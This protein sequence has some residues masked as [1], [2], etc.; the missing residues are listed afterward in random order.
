MVSNNQYQGVTFLV[1]PFFIPCRELFAG[2][3]SQSGAVSRFP[4]QSFAKR[5]FPPQATGNP[6]QQ[7]D[8]RCNRG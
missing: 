1:A 4:L 5:D 7:K 8:F 2:Q 3:S 6:F